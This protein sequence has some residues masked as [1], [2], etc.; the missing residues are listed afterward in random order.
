MRRRA[1]REGIPFFKREI[2]DVLRDKRWAIQCVGFAKEAL[3]IAE[4]NVE[5]YTKELKRYDLSKLLD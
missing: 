5:T 2:E 4:H 3:A 1:K